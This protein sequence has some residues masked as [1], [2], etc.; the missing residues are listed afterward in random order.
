MW[1]ILFLLVLFFCRCRPL[2]FLSH[3]FF[4]SVAFPLDKEGVAVVQD[5]VEDGRGDHVVVE[6]FSPLF[7]GLVRSYD[8]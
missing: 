8:C 4:S 1:Y 7:K 5:P 2:R 3:E 6:D